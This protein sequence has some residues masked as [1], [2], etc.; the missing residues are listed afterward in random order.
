M[1]Q[2]IMHEIIDAIGTLAVYALFLVGL[3]LGLM[4]LWTWVKRLIRRQIRKRCCE[5]CAYAKG[6]MRRAA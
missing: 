3:P 1:L 5:R 4:V 6:M 2:A